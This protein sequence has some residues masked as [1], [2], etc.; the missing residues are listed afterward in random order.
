[1]KRIMV[2][3]WLFL[4]CSSVVA[5]PVKEIVFFGDSLSDD[6]NLYQKLKI[7]PKSPPYYK[8]RFSN[9]LTWAEYVGNH[10]YSKSYS[11][12]L[13]Y[14]YGGATA[15]MHRLRTDKF[16]APMLLQVELDT[17]FT[18]YPLKDKSQSVYALWI[19][20]NDYLYETT[21]DLDSLTSDVVNKISESAETLLDKGA[22]GVM[23][24]NLPDL[25]LT[26]YARNHQTEARLS[27]ISGM[28]NTKLAAVI[29]KLEVKYPG[30]IL[31]FDI[32]GIF[33]DLLSNTDK[34]N[35]KYGTNITN[36][37]E[38]CWLGTV[39]GLQDQKMLESDLKLLNLDD[40]NTQ[41]VIHS[42]VLKQVYLLGSAYSS[43]KTPCGHADQYVFW[44]DL[45]PTA[46]VHKVLGKIIVDQLE[47][48]QWV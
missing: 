29:K 27:I 13:N 46:I 37:T 12:Y 45:H 42:P 28:H 30:R 35:Q 24:L 26:P 16:V 48:K 5:S 33:S 10:F 25:S 41:A 17:Y 36:T 1:M 21:E 2:F 8:G 39:F 18:R 34:Y 11:N 47:S 15:I 3:F 31:L 32:Y 20:A 23:I 38:S 43:G 44:D 40:A 19:G 9:G 4:L 6:G 22:H 14:A 7:V